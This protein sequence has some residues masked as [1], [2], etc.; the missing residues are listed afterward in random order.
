[1]QSMTP[2]RSR[3]GCGCGLVLLLTALLLG[4]LFLGVFSVISSY[5]HSIYIHD[6]ARVLNSQQ[7][8]AETSDLGFNIALYTTSSTLYTRSDKL[9]KY[10]RSQEQAALYTGLPVGIQTSPR[11]LIVDYGSPNDYV[12]SSVSDV[13]TNTLNAGGSLTQAAVAAIHKLKQIY[14]LGF[15]DDQLRVLGKDIRSGL[16]SVLGP[17]GTWVLVVVVIGFFLVLIVGL[18][19]L[20]WFGLRVARARGSAS[21]GSIP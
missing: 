7:V 10:M 11:M 21:P 8:Q 2:R 19:A 4:A 16:E 18:L 3:S 14:P 20:Y 6:N 9:V 12:N 15:P 17:V 5:D 1:M 13:F